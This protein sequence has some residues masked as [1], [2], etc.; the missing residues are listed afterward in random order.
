MEK[1][2]RDDNMKYIDKW[3]RF[4]KQRDIVIVEYVKALK[5]HQILELIARYVVMVRN[6]KIIWGIYEI[7]RKEATYTRNAKKFHRLILLH[8]KNV[9]NK[10]FSMKSDF[11]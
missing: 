11:N 8:F 2:K 5:T 6:I 1:D 7:K 9:L 4:R 3:V 10:C